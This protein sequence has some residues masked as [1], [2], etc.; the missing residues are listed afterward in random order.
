MAEQ[1]ITEDRVSLA[2]QSY[3]LRMSYLWREAQMQELGNYLQTVCPK[4]EAKMTLRNLDIDGI[5]GKTSNTALK[6]GIREDAQ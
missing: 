6:L 3:E 2:P 4:C 5:F 1:M